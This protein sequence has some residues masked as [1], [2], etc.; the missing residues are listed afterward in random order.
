MAAFEESGDSTS[1]GAAVPGYESRH[2]AIRG[3]GEPRQIGGL[4]G[5]LMHD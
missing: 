4:I 5:L 2:F 3:S 1:A